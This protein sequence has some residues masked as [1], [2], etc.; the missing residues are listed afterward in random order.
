MRLK[1]IIKLFVPPIIPKIIHRIKKTPDFTLEPSPLPQIEHHSEK[2]I[3]LGNGPSLN[4]SVEKNKEI[5]KNNDCI[6]V[7]YFA[8]TDLYEQLQPSIY[9]LADPAYFSTEGEFK[10]TVQELIQ[11]LIEKTTWP[12]NLIVPY[13]S[14][15]SLS[16]NKIK[17]NRNIK[18]LPYN[19]IG[20]IPQGLSLYES[21]DMNYSTPPVQTVLNLCI[22]LSIY[23]GYKETFLLGADTSFISNLRIDQKNNKVYSIESHFYKNEEIYKDENLFDSTK[24]RPLNC[25]LWQELLA[26]TNVFKNYMELQKY[27]EYKG[28]RI[29][30]ASEYS[31]IDAFERK[32]IDE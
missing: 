23:W 26:I 1:R 25:P 22:Y 7:N 14:A 9:V 32:L 8:L 31:W 12:I 10:N 17:G 30:N 29:Y 21:W 20:N 4:V 13:S 27:A 19:D 24:M 28:Q 15:N 16:I 5:I 6:V 18:V 11:S 3:I 2:M